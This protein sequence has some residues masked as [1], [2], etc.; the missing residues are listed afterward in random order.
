MDSNPPVAPPTNKEGMTLEDD[1][2]SMLSEQ[3][4]TS[5]ES[6]F[7]VRGVGNLGAGG[8]GDST[9]RCNDSMY[10]E[11][12]GLISESEDGWQ[13][14]D[15]NIDNNHI[16][17]ISEHSSDDVTDSEPEEAQ[18]GQ[19]PVPKKPKKAK[20]EKGEKKKKKKKKLEEE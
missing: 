18:E 15:L 7:R 1:M 3:F 14:H 2:E 10:D 16:D 11:D 4:N 17:D 6:M 8:A 12:R 20:G 19:E 13:Q 5:N 9:Y